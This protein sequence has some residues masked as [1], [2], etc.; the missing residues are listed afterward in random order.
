MYLAL[1]INLVYRLSCRMLRVYISQASQ[2]LMDFFAYKTL[3]RG[4]RLYAQAHPNRILKF[5][6]RRARLLCSRPLGR[7]SR[8]RVSE[9]STQLISFK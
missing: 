4:A 5:S 9:V 6:Q 2:A 7:W 1:H 3:T 8:G